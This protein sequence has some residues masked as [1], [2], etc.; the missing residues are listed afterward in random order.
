MGSIPITRKARFDHIELGQIDAADRTFALSWP[1]ERGVDELMEKIGLS[2]TLEPVWL[3]RVAESLCVVDGFRRLAAARKVGVGELP[4]LVFPAGTDRKALVLARCRDAEGRL[5]A[6][7]VTR[8]VEK[9]SDHFRINDRG[10]VEKFLPLMGFGASPKVLADLRRLSRLEEPVAR[11]CADQA[12]GLR[13]ALLWAGFPREGQRSIL[14]LVRSLKPSGNL[15]RSYL[16]LLHE[17]SIRD[18][19]PVQEALF[20]RAI[21]EVMTDP[22]QAAS[23]GREKVHRILLARRNPA[24]SQLIK[25]FKK[26]SRELDLP[27]GASLDAPPQF[28]GNQFEVSFSF[29]SSAELGEAARKL[30]RLAQSG[31]ADKLFRLLG[32]S[33]KEH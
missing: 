6:V 17:I 18:S 32:A 12:V 24:T 28:E 14:V 16:R 23:G 22:E 13:E 26:L 1:A 33:E 8:L 25:R 11:W 31:E 5:S 2:G 3:I 10:L 4:A 30:E 29:G 15:L 19:R 9:L 7:E 20:D 21:R 27:E